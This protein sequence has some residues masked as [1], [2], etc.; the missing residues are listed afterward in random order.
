[1]V[2]ISRVG[3]GIVRYMDFKGVNFFDMSLKE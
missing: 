2:R 1:M 3:Y